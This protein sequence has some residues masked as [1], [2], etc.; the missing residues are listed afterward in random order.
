MTFKSFMVGVSA[1]ALLGVSGPALAQDSDIEAL[2]AQLEALTQRLQE[3]EAKQAE[4]AAE[5]AAAKAEAAKA[6]AQS[7]GGGDGEAVVSSGTDRVRLK[8]SGQ[9][10]RALQYAD[11]SD[12]SDLM[13][14][15]NDAS[16]TRF[17]FEGEADINEDVTV[18]TRIELE[19]ESDS[20]ANTGFDDDS[21]GFD[22]NERHLDLFASSKKWGKVWL[23]QGSTASDGSTEVDLSGT[24]IVGYSDTASIA[25]G[26][27]FGGTTTTVNDAFDNLDGLGRDDRLRYD[28]PQFA[29]FTVSGSYGRNDQYDG[30]VRF[31]GKFDNTTLRAAVFYA[32][33]SNNDDSYGGSVSADISGFTLT[34]AYAERDDAIRSDLDATFYYGKVGY[35]FSV[36]DFGDSAVAVDYAYN[37]DVDTAGDEATAYGAYYVQQVDAAAADLYLGL[38]NFELERSGVSDPDDVFAVMGGARVKF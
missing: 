11:N 21:G 36:F 34:G 19:V 32:E 12:E 20:S 25:G 10:N 16:S 35:K 31:S 6:A 33:K 2:K 15:D 5:V 17:R 27:N 22:L 23:G 9:V 8:I 24:D 13:P 30:A 7:S 18:G 1:A 14:V 28:S 29:G 3:L 38:R 4:Q 26:I 37:E